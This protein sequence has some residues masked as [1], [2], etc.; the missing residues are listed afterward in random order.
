MI[1]GYR[2]TM[3]TSESVYDGHANTPYSLYLNKCSAG[4]AKTIVD[5]DSKTIGQNFCNQQN[6][7]LFLCSE[8][9]RAGICLE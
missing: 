1:T 2:V 9:F 5:L 6:F 4:S 7:V 3:Q 8:Q